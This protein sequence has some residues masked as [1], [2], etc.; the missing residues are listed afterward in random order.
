MSQDAI[1]R[2]LNNR[3]HKDQIT[4]STGRSS[5]LVI[6]Q[7]GLADALNPIQSALQNS[8]LKTSIKHDEGYETDLIMSQF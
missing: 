2:G 4:G 1:T 7:L 6:S 3:I 8:V 5:E